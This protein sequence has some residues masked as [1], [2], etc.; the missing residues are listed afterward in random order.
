MN[1][2]TFLTLLFFALCGVMYLFRDGWRVLFCRKLKKPYFLV[3]ADA[4]AFEGDPEKRR[5]L[6]QLSVLLSRP[7]ARYLV[8][9]VV[10]T[11]I[12]PSEIL[13]AMEDFDIPVLCEDS[14]E[15]IRRL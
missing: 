5:A 14:K 1:T 10:L 15:V 2:L 13:E 8:K 3:A 6:L 11:N 9:E 4:R 12:A 7:E